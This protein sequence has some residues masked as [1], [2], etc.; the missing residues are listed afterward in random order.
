MHKTFTKLALSMCLAAVTTP[1]MAETVTL[2]TE[3]N[4]VQLQGNLLSFDG[5]KILFA[6]CRY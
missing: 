4:S 6:Y 5:T 3:N 1:A 2:R